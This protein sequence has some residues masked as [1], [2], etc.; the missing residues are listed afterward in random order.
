MMSDEA[1]II[2]ATGS[3]NEWN[4]SYDYASRLVS[5]LSVTNLPHRVHGFF[6]SF[7][8]LISRKN[9]KVRDAQCLTAEQSPQSIQ[10]YGY[11]LGE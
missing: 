2:M 1:I 4:L 5:W 6:S 9:G 11:T 7:L 3:S 8:S 10:M